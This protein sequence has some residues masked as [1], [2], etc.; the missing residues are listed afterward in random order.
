MK[1]K[2]LRKS[3]KKVKL[4]KRN[5]TFIVHINGDYA[6]DFDDKNQAYD[7]YR[8]WVIRIAYDYF[9]MKPKHLIF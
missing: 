8:T 5:E 1:A 9:G 2:L 7:Y 3:R 6:A 4:Y